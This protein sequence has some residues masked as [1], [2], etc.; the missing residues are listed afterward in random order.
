MTSTFFDFLYDSFQKMI[1]LD[2]KSHKLAT[3]KI[4]YRNSS[5]NKVFTMYQKI[6]K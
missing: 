5:D 3:T 1:Y 6:W 2:F 4:S